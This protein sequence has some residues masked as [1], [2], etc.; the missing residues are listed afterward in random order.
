MV[1][2][3]TSQ[4]LQQ[5]DCQGY[6]SDKVLFGFTAASAFPAQAWSLPS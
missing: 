6:M 5:A 1:M 4:V 2:M 3:M